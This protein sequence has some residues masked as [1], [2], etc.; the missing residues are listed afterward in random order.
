M[1]KK[2]RISATDQ[3]IEEASKLGASG[4]ALFEALKSTQD[5]P[6]RKCPGCG[7]VFMHTCT[8]KTCPSCKTNLPWAVNDATVRVPLTADVNEVPDLP[9]VNSAG[10]ITARTN[11]AHMEPTGLKERYY[12]VLRKQGYSA[13]SMMI[14]YDALHTSDAQIRLFLENKLIDF[15]NM[16]QDYLPSLLTSKSPYFD[17]LLNQATENNWDQIYNLDQ[18]TLTNLVCGQFVNKHPGIDCANKVVILK[19]NKTR[20]GFDGIFAIIH[21][22]PASTIKNQ[23]NIEVVSNS[24]I[25]KCPRCG[26]AVLKGHLGD[27]WK[28]GTPLDRVRG[29]ATC[30]CGATFPQRDVYEGKYDIKS[31]V[32]IMTGY[33]EIS[34]NINVVLFLLNGTPA[35]TTPRVACSLVL[36]KKYPKA[37]LGTYFIIG[38]KI[39]LT[40]EEAYIHYL[41]LIRS[42]Q[43]TDVGE[44][45]DAEMTTLEERQIVALYF[46]KPGESFES[47]PYSKDVDG[48]TNDNA[49]KCYSCKFTLEPDS[50]VCP[51]CRALV[52]Y[53]PANFPSIS[54]PLS[55]DDYIQTAITPLFHDESESRRYDQPEFENVRNKR[56]SAALGE[57]QRLLEANPDFDLLYLWLSEVYS[58][59]SQREDEIKILNMGLQQSK[60]KSTLLDH[61]AEIQWSAKNIENALYLWLQSLFASSESYSQAKSFLMMYYVAMGTDLPFLANLFIKR[62]DELRAGQVRLSDPT[63]LIELATKQKNERIR[64]LLFEIKRIFFDAPTPASRPQEDYRNRLTGNRPAPL[65][66]MNEKDFPSAPI[67]QTKQESI[68]E[69]APP[70]DIRN[71]R[72]LFKPGE[73]LSFLLGAGISV[74]APASIP[75]SDSF[76]AEI[77]SI[78][79]PPEELP[80]IMEFN[81]LDYDIVVE[82][83]VSTIDKQLMF[84]DF[85][86]K[87]NS[88]NLNHYFLAKMAQKGHYIF[89][90]NFDNMLERALELTIGKES[91]KQILS[92][93][94][95]E[96]FQQYSETQALFDSGFYPI[97]KLHGSK[98]NYISNQDC[99]ESIII[100]KERASQDRE[101]RQTFGVE[102]FKRPAIRH[103][104]FERTLV[105]IG[106]AGN[107][108]FD[109]MPMLYSAE[110]VTKIIWIKHSDQ[111][112]I[113]IEELTPDSL[114]IPEDQLKMLKKSISC[115]IYRINTNALF[116]IKKYLWKMLLASEPYPA[117]DPRPGIEFGRWIEKEYSKLTIS[118]LEKYDFIAHLCRRSNHLDKALEYTMK[119]L[120]LARAA[121]KMDLEAQYSHSIGM[122]C[123]MKRDYSQALQHL[124]AANQLLQNPEDTSEGRFQFYSNQANLLN[125]I[126]LAH[127]YLKEPDK[128]MDYYQKALNIMVE[129]NLFAGKNS[130]LNNIGLIYLGQKKYDEAL[131]LF[132][133]ALELSEQNGDVENKAIYLKHMAIVYSNRKQFEEANN[134]L[135]EALKINKII[136]DPS[137]EGSDYVNL[138]CLFKVQNDDKRA[139][140]YFE[141]AIQIYRQLN[142]FEDVTYLEGL[143]NDSKKDPHELK[144]DEQ[145]IIPY[146]AFAN[147][148]NCLKC[149]KVIESESW[150]VHGDGVAFYYQEELGNFSLPIKCP[151]CN[152][153]W[154][155]VWD[156][157]PGP[158]GR[159]MFGKSYRT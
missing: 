50:L 101:R 4:P 143:I 44:Q 113:S 69:M 125:D 45:F 116:F 17:I 94:T 34:S 66:P 151:W 84:M 132:Q 6:A 90:T 148:I 67:A 102:P 46:K 18:K 10:S 154:Y 96:D 14:I 65:P 36:E 153:S 145:V 39:S 29:T 106:Y 72:E 51:R 115:P 134:F 118:D 19:A 77:L 31:D 89:T 24:R 109:I 74:D 127:Y 21:H 98:Y 99:S 149:G 15:N 114:E 52:Y 63:R 147:K 9:L 131:P 33:Q 146:S 16:M 85:Y 26:N 42:K 130:T 138:G 38:M 139:L 13:V 122:L 137:E 140:E 11:A 88:P 95:R 35:P 68:Q 56:D 108:Q 121:P 47:L 97:Y 61:L 7:S 91:R 87:C 157:N 103:L 123:L 73:K 43:I 159:M 58:K 54:L 25:W 112:G 79:C 141:K 93:I 135:Q 30:Q 82:A 3:D 136:N 8:L 70:E 158:L 53:F 150:P 144:I 12:D 156:N 55:D 152:E 76:I 48:E 86:E 128:A 40:V 107:D 32:K 83:L 110:G 41:E 1:K 129:F 59:L 27:I 75:A 124:E 71:L 117:F 104:F 60:R 105:V 133:E 155:V 64:K 28:P 57:G 142:K 92:V 62:A 37:M 80:T 23:A 120:Q 119:A 22:C 20:Y 126:G 78:C 49:V 5:Q 111:A 2:E 81:N 100:T